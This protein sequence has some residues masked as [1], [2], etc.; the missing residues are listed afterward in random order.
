MAK[1]T[2]IPFQIKL[3]EEN[4]N[5]MKTESNKLGINM[6]AFISM[7]ITQYDSTNIINK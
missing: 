2:R 1:V 6:S 4:Y 3:T 7:L 5:K